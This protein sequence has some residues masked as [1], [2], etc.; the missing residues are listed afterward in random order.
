MTRINLVPVEE[1]YDQHLI[2]EYREITMVPASLKR[3]LKSPR[4]KKDK[5][6]QQF[7][8]NKGHVTFFY[9]KGL[10]L[11]QR[12]AMLVFEMK[13]RGM[14]PNSERR[15]PIEVFPQDYQNDWAPSLED[16]NTSRQRIEIRLAEKPG[17]Y[18]KTDIIQET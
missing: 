14:K 1:L 9:D 18:R 4:W 11:Q 2:A 7:T 6:P 3:S 16:I 17:W 10:F 15:F 5:I 8:L 12:Y 13:R